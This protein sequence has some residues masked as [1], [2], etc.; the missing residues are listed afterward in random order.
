MSD[1]RT[2]KR[3]YPKILIDRGPKSIAFIDTFMW[4]ELLTH[5]DDLRNSIAVCCKDHATTFAIT[6]VIESELAQRNFLSGVQRICTDKLVS[7]PVGRITANQVI[8]ALV[9]YERQRSEVV[10]TWELE[11]SEVPVLDHSVQGLKD[12]IGNLADEL[13]QAKK[14]INTTKEGLVSTLVN[15]EREMWR[16]ALR[17]YG[18]I[19]SETDREF[20]LQTGEER[21]TYNSFFLTDYF[22]DLPAVVL[23]SYLF[24][25]LMNERLVKPQDVIDI[26]TLSELLPYCNLFIMDRDQH[27]RL[28]SLQRDYPTGFGRLD[29]LCSISSFLKNCTLT[30]VS[31]LSTFLA[32]ELLRTSTEA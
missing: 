12:L 9:C 1:H 10:L 19:F 15:T 16:D 30:P 20:K 22:T 18:D 27:N 31:A 17:T 3:Y 23:R 6:S 5:L 11:L 21:E 8:H 13:N 4:G 2:V 25:Y 26:Y 32:K 14:I 29:Q 28:M 24:A 7:I